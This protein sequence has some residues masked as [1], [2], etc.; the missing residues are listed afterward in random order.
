VYL[1]M[2]NELIKYLRCPNTGQP[3]LLDKMKSENN[4]SSELLISEDKNWTYEIENGIP[5]FVSNSNYADNF[6]LQWNHF[7]ETQ[8]DSFSGQ[9]ISSDRFWNATGWDK[10]DLKG[11]WV[12]DIGCGAGRFAEVVLK[13][14]ANVI[15]LDYS[16]AVDACYQNLKHF[17]N[18]YVIQGDIYNLP[19]ANESFSYIYSLGVL[20]HTPDVK[21]A[22]LA[23]PPLLKKGGHLCV[24]Y[25]WKRFRT[26]L[27]SKYL[28]RPITTRLPQKILFAKLE[29]WIPTLMRF[30]QELNRVP[31]FGTILKRIVPVAD[32]TG[33]Y[34]LSDKQ[35]IDW[36]L[37]DTFD[38]LAPKYDNPQT[39]NT[40]KNWLVKSGLINIEVF[41][42]SHL[43][44]R[45]TKP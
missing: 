15:A 13:A 42:A 19:F 22:F 27:H 35:L 14:G 8:L 1:F 11:E 32:Y 12:L 16:S 33:V 38:M 40:V 30:S 9:K 26:M 43:V 21:K 44:G 18:L 23:L 25:Y 6:G 4:N 37:L 45:G 28:F 20:Q 36:A 17:P 24:D 2:N 31:L 7:R 29:K 41:H 3:L 10:K 34:P 39:A 5:R